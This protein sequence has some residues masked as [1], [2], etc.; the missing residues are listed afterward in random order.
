MLNL[1]KIKQQLPPG[2]EDNA[3]EFYISENEIKCLHKGVPYFW[4][5]FPEWIITKIEEDMLLNPDAVK[6]LV[7]WDITQR[8]D[9]MRQYIICRFGGFDGNADISDNG[10]IEHVEYFECGR[11]G[12]CSYEGKLC[13]SIKVGNEHLTKQEINVIK[14]IATGKSNRIIAD[15]LCISEE[16]V[17]THNQNIQRKLG[18][19]SKLEIIPWAVRR[20]IV[21]P[22]S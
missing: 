2:L 14:K 16:T 21:E 3:V 10:S 18:V 11:R 20:N 13:A 12:N 22:Q 8:D 1:S 19:K 17:N 15:E 6:A 5:D 4:G 9:M 7:S